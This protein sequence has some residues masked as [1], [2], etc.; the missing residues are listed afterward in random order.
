MHISQCSPSLWLVDQ[1]P[2]DMIAILF[3]YSSR[4]PHLKH[5]YTLGLKLSFLCIG[6]VVGV[7]KCGNNVLK[8]K[9]AQPVNRRLVKYR[10]LEGDKK[11][12]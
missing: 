9:H 4:G 11:L 7:V 2:V 5:A 12:T 10:S 6:K 1:L 3:A 8:N